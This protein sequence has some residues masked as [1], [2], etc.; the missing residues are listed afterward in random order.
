M[1]IL[2]LLGTGEV[3]TE[4]G[5]SAST[6]ITQL[7]NALV[8]NEQDVTVV[9]VATPMPRSALDPRVN[10]IEVDMPTPHGPRKHWIE[11]LH[12]RIDRRLARSNR[13]QRFQR[14]ATMSRHRKYL[15]ACLRRVDTKAF[16]VVHLHHGMQCRPAHE[17]YGLPYVYTSHWAFQKEDVSPGAMLEREIVK[18]AQ[19]AIGLGEYL[20]EFAPD[21]NVRVIP[22]GIELK[23]WGELN[24]A[25][26]R[27]ELGINADAFSLVF[28]G[29]V[30]QHKG[31]D[32]L[33][34]AAHRLAPDIPGLKVTVIGPLGKSREL[35]SISD[36]ANGI[37]KEA[38]GL[39]IQFPGF[40]PYRS[41]ELRRHLA[42]A[43]L[44]VFPSRHEAQGLAA[45]EA[46]AMG[47]PV[48][49]SRVGGLGEMIT[50]EIGELVVPGDAA[51]L[52]DA[53]R[54]LYRDP[55]RIAAMRSVCRAYVRDHFTWDSVARRYIQAFSDLA[56]Q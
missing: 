28:V 8:R 7:S 36:Y 53:I 40:V 38:E 32:V 9:D 48:V 6:V 51:A 30:A 3:G 12:P 47:T 24:R 39:N 23:H 46:V 11:K 34:D 49:A 25:E 42:A 1:K 10:V 56:S 20:H 41:V 26:A 2:E 14:L 54:A 52:A 27:K 29:F 15:A 37:I 4:E 19:V 43:D 45:L 50:P 17:K 44:F 18:N 22:H 35:E 13:F 16:D 21:A 31:V 33:V 5:N 55:D